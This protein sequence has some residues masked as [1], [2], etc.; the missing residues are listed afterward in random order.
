MTDFTGSFFSLL[1]F[2]SPK[3]KEPEIDVRPDFGTP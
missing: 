1:S 3:E 2:A